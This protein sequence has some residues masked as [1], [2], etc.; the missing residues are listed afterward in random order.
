[1]SAPPPLSSKIRRWEHRAAIARLINAKAAR[2]RGGFLAF[3]RSGLGKKTHYLTQIDPVTSTGSCASCGADVPIR[4]RRSTGRWVCQGQDKR[5]SHKESSW[6]ATRAQ[7]AADQG[8]Q[9]AICGKDR[10]LVLDHCHKTGKIRAAL[11]G[12]CNS[13]LGMFQDD[14]DVLCKALAYVLKHKD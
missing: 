2:E 3:R 7:L 12:A 13:G 8:N 5:T 11:C 6:T 9:C 1:M 4:F 14:P 10:P